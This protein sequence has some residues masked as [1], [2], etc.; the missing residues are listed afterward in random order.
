MQIGE[1]GQGSQL[2]QIITRL[3]LEKGGGGSG[4]ESYEVAAYFYSRHVDISK[5]E[6]PFFFITGDEKMYKTITPDT[7]TRLFGKEIIHG[8]I[9]SNSIWYF[10]RSIISIG[11][12]CFPSTMCFT[13]TSPTTTQRKTPK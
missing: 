2:D 6:M 12:S 3:F 8:D 7:I 11:W 5:A 4:E 13:F 1:F 9:N 10:F